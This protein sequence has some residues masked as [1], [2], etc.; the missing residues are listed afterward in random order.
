MMVM[1]ENR[2]GGYVWRGEIVRSEGE[3]ARGVINFCQA[4][5]VKY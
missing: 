1:L 3:G 4:H 2:F 5:A